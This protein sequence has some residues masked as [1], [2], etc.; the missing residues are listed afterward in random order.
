LV[1][2]LL[3]ALAALIGAAML[4]RK[5]SIQPV[6]PLEVRVPN[7][8]ESNT[9]DVRKTAA[10]L[11]L[12]IV[13]TDQQGKQSPL[14]EGVV[15]GQSPAPE[16]LVSLGTEVRLQVEAA[17]AVVPL[18]VGMTLD[19][20]VAALSSVKLRL[21]AAESAPAL[22]VTPGTIIK[23]SPEAGI[24]TAEGSQVNVTFAAPPSSRGSPASIP[25]NGRA[26]E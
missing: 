25:K 6:Q 1:L 20:A 3:L 23:Q 22:K 24:R 9:S 17:T 16:Q 2:V 7:F 4:W 14:L 13:F 8:V 10:F 18:I 15:V 26:G 11:N 21:G 12:N 19:G 5:S